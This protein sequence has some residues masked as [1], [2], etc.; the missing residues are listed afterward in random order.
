MLALAL[1]AVVN[2]LSCPD[3]SWSSLLVNTVFQCFF[4]LLKA[5]LLGPVAPD[6]R[7]LNGSQAVSI[8][9]VGKNRNLG[10]V[11]VMELA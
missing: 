4:K 5:R 10:F 8:D 11:P 1:P 9:P 6:F 7:S 3:C 2:V